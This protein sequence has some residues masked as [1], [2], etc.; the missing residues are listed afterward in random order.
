[1]NGGSKYA[2]FRTEFI[3][4]DIVEDDEC[5]C[6]RIVPDTLPDRLVAINPNFTKICI[7]NDDSKYYN[8]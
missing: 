8:L 3:N 7:L 6:L 4:D 5:Y 2:E 1:M